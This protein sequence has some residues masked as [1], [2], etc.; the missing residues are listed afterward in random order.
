ML[1][2]S[3]QPRRIADSDSASLPQRVWSL[4]NSLDATLSVTSSGRNLSTACDAEP[5]C[6]TFR[7]I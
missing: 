3:T 4:A 6:E 2:A 5:V 7:V 1:A